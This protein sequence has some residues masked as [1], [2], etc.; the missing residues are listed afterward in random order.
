VL[1]KDNVLNLTSPF[2]ATSNVARAAAWLGTFVLLGAGWTFLLLKSS[3][4]SLDLAG[5]KT[6]VAAMLVP[7]MLLTLLAWV[8]LR[9]SMPQAFPDGAAPAA[10]PSSVSAEPAPPAAPMWRIGAWGVVTP[11]GAA[12]AT[13]ERTLAQE[14]MFRP[15]A[16][17]RNQD[18]HPLHAAAA[19]ALPLQ[20]LGYPGETRQR[21]MRVSA[22]L[23]TVLNELHDQQ[24]EL[25]RS[26]DAPAT[27]LWL[28]PAAIAPD[29]EARARFAAA[30]AHSS[31]REVEYR[32]QIVPVGAG[33]AYGVA[34]DLRRQMEPARMP[35][36]L[37]L[38]ADSLLDAEELAPQLALGRVFSDRAP[39]GF[40]PAEGA[41]G[42]LLVHP[43]FAEQA[44]LFG[45]S[46][47]GP[48]HRGQHASD[49]AGQAKADC[50]VLTACITEAMAAASTS[51]GQIGALFC[52][53]DHRAA[54]V[55]EATL[56]M[57]QVLPG[58][59]PLLQ[60]LSPMEHAGCFG[61]AA[62]LVH[63]ALAAEMAATSQQ[64]ILSLGLGGDRQ[65]AAL[66]ILPE[67]G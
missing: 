47:I 34:D 36:V 22:M 15:D 21:A 63:M 9:I 19:K 26:T 6:M 8:G 46:T 13:I 65:V 58:L 62:D 56:A 29:D 51:A 66:V 28:V 37:L 64:P 27:V 12:A 10:G 52:D 44:P 38:A 3:P 54:G 55:M 18:G 50:S 1:H 4:K 32:L 39:N 42:L 2:T 14:K 53:T 57:G 45:L 11:H 59:D 60:R 23:A 17:I 31:W 43:V 25:A 61:A 16:A 33:G 49:R 41:G 20:P 30:W 24:I 40:I 48:A 35:Y 7:P 5:P 67:Q